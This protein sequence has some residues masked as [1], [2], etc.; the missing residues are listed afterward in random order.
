MDT[1]SQWE[2]KA[3][4]GHIAS[5]LEIATCVPLPTDFS[6]DELCPSGSKVFYRL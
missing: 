5:D 4:S 6:D 1:T 3:E 2:S